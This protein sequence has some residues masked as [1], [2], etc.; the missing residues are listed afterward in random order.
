MKRFFGKRR[1]TRSAL[2]ELSTPPLGR[3]GALV[4]RLNNSDKLYWAS[5]R[6]PTRIAGCALSLWLNCHR[7]GKRFL[8]ISPNSAREDMPSNDRMTISFSLCAVI[9][10]GI[11]RHVARA[12]CR[13]R[14]ASA[15]HERTER[16]GCTAAEPYPLSRSKSIRQRLCASQPARRKMYQKNK[17]KG[18]TTVLIAGRVTPCA[19]TDCNQKRR[20]RSDAP[21]L[22]RL[23]LSAFTEALR[24]YESPSL[25]PRGHMR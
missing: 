11:S 18:L 14:D 24:R 25:I 15:I 2:G 19:P 17:P 20:A 8:R 16:S 7:L 3:L 4:F 9:A 23:C 13:E 12:Q 21:Y 1:A 22:L 6:A 10:G 5:L